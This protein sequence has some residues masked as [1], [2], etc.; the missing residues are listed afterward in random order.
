MDPYEFARQ[1]AADG[2]S[3]KDVAAA[4]GL[5]QHKFRIWL[6]FM[7]AIGWPKPKPWESEK[8][9]AHLQRLNEGRAGIYAEHFRRT[10]EKA[11]TTRRR[12]I[13]A[14][15]RE[16]P[17]GRPGSFKEIAGSNGVSEKALRY[18]L[19]QGFRLKDAIAHAQQNHLKRARTYTAFGVT[20]P[21]SV[22]TRNFGVVTAKAVAARL[23]KGMSIEKALTLPAQHM[24]TAHA[25]KTGHIWLAHNNAMFEELAMRKAG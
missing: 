7:P 10:A 25:P 24:K 13:E 6:G 14:A 22:L 15:L 2:W 1:R 4:L 18:W 3:Q 17:H 12:N 21:L 5:T 16:H 11:K 20:G 8:A 23:S 19:R 9:K